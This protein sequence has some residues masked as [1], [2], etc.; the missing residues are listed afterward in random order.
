MTQSFLFFLAI[1]GVIVFARMEIAAPS[2]SGVQFVAANSS[3]PSEKDHEGR[4]IEGAKKEGKVVF[5][6]AGGSAQEWRKSIVFADVV[7]RLGQGE[8][9]RLSEESRQK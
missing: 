6:H 3:P 9:G 7:G 8:D 2:L 1:A 4:L 5:W